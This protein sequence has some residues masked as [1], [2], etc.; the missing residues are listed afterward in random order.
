MHLIQS[1]QVLKN[2]CERSPVSFCL[3]FFKKIINFFLRQLLY[4]FSIKFQKIL[5]RKLKYAK[6]SSS[7]LLNTFRKKRTG[8]FTN[9]SNLLLPN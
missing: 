8:F 7:T 2:V 6:K 4:S 3:L 1:M 9:T 5:P